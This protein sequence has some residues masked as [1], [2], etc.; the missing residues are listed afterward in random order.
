MRASTLWQPWASL[1]AIGA[2]PY[3]T[4]SYPPPAKLIGQRIAIHAAVKPIKAVW[5]TLDGE[6]RAAIE[7]ALHANGLG[8][9]PLELPH[10]SVV[11][12]AVL[13]GAYQV[14]RIRDRDRSW[15]ELRTPMGMCPGN[16]PPPNG[17]AIPTDHFGDY[18]HCRWAWLLTDVVRLD[19]PVPAKGKQGWWFW[20]PPAMEA[21]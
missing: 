9:F 13:A 17:G 10:G 11:A 3:E 12:T 16:V 6:T 19:Q 5:A 18:S 14:M 15:L 20:E 1:V 4:R 8:Q 21:A 2:K 7:R